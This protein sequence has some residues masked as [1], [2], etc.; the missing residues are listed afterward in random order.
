MLKQNKK[1]ELRQD[2]LG[3]LVEHQRSKQRG[4]TQTKLATAIDVDPSYISK[5]EHG[6]ET[7]SLDKLLLLAENLELYDNPGLLLNA[8]A[9]R[10][11]LDGVLLE[12]SVL[13]VPPDFTMQEW[14][15]LRDELEFIM[16]KR[17]RSLPLDVEP[18]DEE[19][20]E[21][22]SRQIADLQQTLTRLQ[23]REDRRKKLNNETKPQAL[24]KP[25]G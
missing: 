14:A 22:L 12:S 16:W 5:L 6:K 13:Q 15:E 25:S 21:E 10:V 23:E 17:N 18:A 8:L 24:D 19:T 20:T 3:K 11:T 7:P 1:S 4:M 2:L 9:G